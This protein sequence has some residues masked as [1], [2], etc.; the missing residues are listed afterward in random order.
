M[1]TNPQFAELIAMFG[2]WSIITTVDVALERC[3]IHSS[4]VLVHPRAMD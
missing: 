2:Q 4:F 3:P 1:D